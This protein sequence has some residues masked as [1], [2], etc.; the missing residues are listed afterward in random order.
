[1][2]RL[3]PFLFFIAVISSNAFTQGI[4]NL[5]LMGYQSWAGPPYGGT[6]LDFTGGSLNLS[7]ESRP[8]YFLATNSVICN[9]LGNLLFCSNGI[10]VANAQFD[11]MQNGNGL[12]PA[13]YTS[14]YDTL[15][16]PI[17]QANLV[18]P[19]PDTSNKYYLFHA[20]CDDYGYSY[21]TLFMYYSIIDMTLDS[22]KGAVIQKNEVLINDSLVDGRFTACKH[23][24]GRDWWVIAHQ[25]HSDLYYKWLIAP[26]GII[27][28]YLQDIG[29]SRDVN[30]GQC[31]FSRDGSHF[32]YYETFADLDIMDFDRCTGDFSNLV[33]VDFNDSAGRGGVAF[34]PNSDVLYVTSENYIYQF[35]MTAANVAASQLT[36]ATYD[37]YNSPWP[38]LA[39]LFYMAQL[40]PD[41]K[42]Y[43]VCGN[44]TLDIHV[45]NFPDSLGVGCDVCQ[46]CI[47]LPSYNANS[48]ANHPNFFL[49]AEGGTICDSL[50][51]TISNP[52]SLVFDQLKIFPSPAKGTVEVTFNYNILQEP[53]EISIYNI[54]G[55]RVTFYLLPVWSSIQKV[56]LPDL[57]GGIYMARLKSKDQ[58]CSVKFVV[59]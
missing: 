27:G 24:N 41:G 49:G 12:N 14:Q 50:P 8:I 43:I 9:T 52:N 28:P 58:T 2:K 39:T 13:F 23:A 16:L 18:I 10:Y 33:H 59:E 3:I 34:S 15:G 47:A 32:A 45:I 37:G 51:T 38:P 19:F 40:A 42:I 4:N 55:K 29:E 20:T 48:V 54:D 25:F 44:T 11:T 36:V 46:H 1:M 53:G 57:A 30:F 26:S 5:W 22:G 56:K 7:Y 6:N 31:V 21:A 17:P 35:D